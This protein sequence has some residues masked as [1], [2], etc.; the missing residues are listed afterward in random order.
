MQKVD[1]LIERFPALR[2][3]F[4]FYDADREELMHQTT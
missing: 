4:I 1:T 3:H 2:C